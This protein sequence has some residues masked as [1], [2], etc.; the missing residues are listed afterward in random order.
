MDSANRTRLWVGLGLQWGPGTTT[1]KGATPLQPFLFLSFLLTLQFYVIATTTAQALP[2]V[3]FGCR[4][5]HSRL[6]VAFVVTGVILIPQR[7]TGH[8]LAPFIMESRPGVMMTL[9]SSGIPKIP[10]QCG[11]YE[12][13]PPPYL[14]RQG[15]PYQPPYPLPLLLPPPSSTT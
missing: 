12:A 6:L 1:P 13:K 7:S 8:L 3:L 9:S 15:R 14:T 5:T 11:L 10:S 2:R 4:D